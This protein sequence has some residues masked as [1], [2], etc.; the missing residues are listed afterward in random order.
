LLN[1]KFE[2][3]NGW[4][5]NGKEISSAELSNAETAAKYLTDSYA[6]REWTRK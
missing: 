3:P 4:S 6:G 1:V 5:V 2:N